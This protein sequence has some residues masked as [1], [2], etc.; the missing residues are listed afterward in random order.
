M[1]KPVHIPFWDWVIERKK[2]KWKVCQRCERDGWLPECE[3]CGG[4][5]YRMV[6]GQREYFNPYSTAPELYEKEVAEA[7]AKWRRFHGPARS[8][9]SRDG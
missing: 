4:H 7:E 1:N 8:V 6:K 3:E 2:G 5:P 9:D